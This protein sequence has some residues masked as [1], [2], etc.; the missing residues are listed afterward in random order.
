LGGA[1]AALAAL[2]VHASEVELAGAITFGQPRTGD[3]T[4]AN[5]LASLPIVRVVNA[6]DLVPQLPPEAF[7]YA[8]GGRLAHFD[9]HHRQSYA[10]T[11]NLETSVDRLSSAVV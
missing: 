10:Q 5:A 11:L 8:H 3:C 6:C 7:G 9:A 1:L 4:L 2:R